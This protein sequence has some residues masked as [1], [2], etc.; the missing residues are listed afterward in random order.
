[1]VPYTAPIADMRFV[2]N[3]VVGIDR[4]AALPGYEAAS[5]DLV[6]TI[7]DEAGKFAAGVLAP[8]NHIGDHEGSVLENGAVRQ[9]E[10]FRQAYRQY[11]EAGWNSVPFD[12][13][14]DGQGLPWALAFAVQEMWQAANMAFGLCPMLNQGAVDLLTEHGDDQQKATYLAKM[15]S[16]EWT[17]SMDLTEPQAGSDLGTVRTKAVEDGG[18]YR[19]TGQKIFITYGDHD[20]AENIIHLVLA[21]LPDAPAGSKGI[22]LFLVPKFL[23]NPDGSVG[24][25]ND[26]R[27]AGIEHKLG[28]KASPTAVLSY[29]D[30]G[31]AIGYIVGEPNR[32][33]EYMFAMMNNARLSVGLQGV[34]IA[35]R[36]YQQARDYAK[37]RVQ[38]RDL[39]Y[40]KNPP[41]AIINHP[42]VRRMLLTMKAQTEAGR[43]LAYE[44]AGAF[45]I[46]KRHPDAETRTAA[47]LRLELLTPVVKGWCTDMGC[48]VASLG[49]QVHGGMGF[50][51][52]TGAAQ[53]YRDARIAPIYEGTNGI[54][55]N[56]LVFRKLGRDRG[57]AVQAFL[58]EAKA[59]VAELSGR[60]GDDLA[61]IAGGL[62]AGLIVLETAT[63]WLVE[64]LKP[65]PVAAAAGASHYL[66]MFGLVAGAVGL[67]KAAAA[68]D[69]D[70]R[71]RGADVNF[72]TGKLIT[73]RFFAEHLL[74]QAA[75]LLTPITQGHHVVMALTE[76]QF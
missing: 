22:S 31:G 53:H 58:T 10:S 60:P 20:Q 23:V 4:I 27:C 43:I 70:L 42:D 14:Y 40:P 75:G 74:P 73:A 48:E 35:E 32:G 37:V 8:I 30:N 67:A 54:Q 36:A 71:Q 55:A 34:A 5:P 6:E 49:I 64:T 15:I 33:L 9:P 52:E 76:D 12:P 38:S 61:A 63:Q 44:A 62:S 50:I 68:A 18:V 2:L 57:A 39:R 7:L 29:G 41:V 19:I 3:R 16:G 26:V 72:L 69:E 28:I 66:R 24:E 56:D 59:L 13:E 1:M 51:E 65:D 21:R 46:S 47:Q 11:V 45:D 17:G 25:H